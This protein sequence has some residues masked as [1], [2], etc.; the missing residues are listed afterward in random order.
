VVTRSF[1]APRQ[2]IWDCHTKPEL[3]QRWLFGP[4]GWSMP[5]CVID[6]RVGGRY[7]YVWRQLDNSREFGSY[8]H[9]DEVVPVER[10][11]FTEEMDGLDGQPMNIEAP[12]E[13]PNPSVNIMTLVESGGRTTMTLTMRFASKEIR[14]MALQSGMTDGMEVGYRRL[15]AMAAEAAA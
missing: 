12:V 4:E 3:V 11:V 14:D 1:E 10:I 7:R 13:G 9:Y 8:G 6:L 5:Y 2:L 15:D